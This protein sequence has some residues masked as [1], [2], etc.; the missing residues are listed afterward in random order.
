MPHVSIL[1]CTKDRPVQLRRCLES[2]FQASLTDCE[3][4]V[5]D[6]ASRDPSIPQLD[7]PI[8]TRYFSF[9]VPGLSRA[10]NSV[11]SEL[12][13]D[14]VALIDDDVV[15]AKDWM[16]SALRHFDDPNIGCVTGKILPLET[17]SK[18]QQT[19]APDQGSEIQFFDAANFDP[20]TGQPGKGANLFLRKSVLTTFGF[21]ELFGPGTPAYAADEH[22]IFFQVIKAGSKICYEPGSIVYHEYEAGESEFRERARR[23]AISRGVFLS[24]FLFT[25]SGYRWHTFQYLLGRLAG[26]K[27]APSDLP[28]GIRNY[29]ILLGPFA[30]LKSKRHNRDAYRE[31]TS[32]LLKTF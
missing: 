26:K 23:R 10:R 5:V 27:S 25:E 24:K 12:R 1:I 9:P 29:G 28:A 13:G 20:V 2:V 14:I 11:L 31:V 17:E 8:P 30:L 15:V 32:I 18:W 4:V 6:N 19:Q 21:P 3:L 22:Y 16:Q 7:Y